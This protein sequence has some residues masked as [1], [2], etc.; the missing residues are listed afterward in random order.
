M[1]IEMS[2]TRVFPEWLAT[3]VGVD[4]DWAGGLGWARLA[5]WRVRPVTR[6]PYPRCAHR[7]TRWGWH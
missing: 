5:P 2:H 6:L 3:L 7:G 1:G 4:L